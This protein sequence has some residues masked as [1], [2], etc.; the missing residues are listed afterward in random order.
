LIS[1]RELDEDD[2]DMPRLPRGTQL[3]HRASLAPQISFNLLLLELGPINFL[4]EY[5]GI[6][7][8]ERFCREIDNMAE[9]PKAAVF[10]LII[11]VQGC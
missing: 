8:K 10:N 1:S 2:G 9:T 11:D 5:I 7:T 6:G 3:P 4:F